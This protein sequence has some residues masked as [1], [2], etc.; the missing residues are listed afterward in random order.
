[1][2][3]HITCLGLPN[4]STRV[5]IWKDREKAAKIFEDYGHDLLRI[6][7][8]NKILNGAFYKVENSKLQYGART[9]YLDFVPTL[10]RIKGRICVMN[11][12]DQMVGL[13]DAFYHSSDY[14]DDTGRY[15][16]YE[17]FY[18][19]F[20]GKAVCCEPIDLTTER[21]IMAR[22]IT[23]RVPYSVLATKI[24]S[25]LSGGL[26]RFLKHSALELTQVQEE[27]LIAAQLE[28]VTD[29]LSDIFEDEE[30]E[31]GVLRCGQSILDF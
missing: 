14:T 9:D 3:Q 15:H 5:F 31:R 17:I 29:A 27:H 8:I 26:N 19:G 18:T 12:E 7:G 6:K 22:Y 23:I 13:G 21:K 20:S 4:E 25:G 16:P 10:V 24:E 1:M 30:V 28:Y 2:Q 11:N